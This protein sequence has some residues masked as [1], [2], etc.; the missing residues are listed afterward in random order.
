[1]E[2]KQDS[3]EGDRQRDR[4]LAAEVPLL[5]IARRQL[6]DRDRPAAD[7]WLGVVTW[8]QLLPRLSDLS[9]SEAWRSFLRILG[10]EL[11]EDRLGPHATRWC[12]ILTEVRGDVLQAA[13]KILG[14]GEVSHA[15]RGVRA[16]ADGGWFGLRVPADAQ[17]GPAIVIELTGRSEVPAL[18]VEYQPRPDRKLPRSCIDHLLRGQFERMPNGGYRHRDFPKD[19]DQG[20]IRN[21]EKEHVLAAVRHDLGVLDRSGALGWELKD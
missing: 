20:A 6:D 19:V 7:D 10:S 15:N 4:Y 21:P 9:E 3:P 18:T 14:A 8:D 17:D 11:R 12:A 2:L 1:M 5:L 13:Q 16:L